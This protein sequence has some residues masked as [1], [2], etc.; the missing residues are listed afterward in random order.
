MSFALTKFQAYGLY[1]DEAVTKKAIQRVEMTITG[2]AADVDLDI[3]DDSGTFW[4]AALADGTYG[5]YATSALAAIQAVVARS[6]ELSRV[7]I[8]SLLD[9]GA[10]VGRTVTK[11]TSSAGAGGGATEAMTVTGLLSTDLVLAVTQKTD[12]ANN[13]PLLGWSTQADDAITGIWSADPGAGAVIEVAFARE[14][15]APSDGEFS[16]AIQNKRPN[17]T[18]AAG[19]GETS[20]KVIMEYLLDEGVQPVKSDIG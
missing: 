6:Q 17:I 7:D 11:I 3:G 16:L 15:G 10:P 14:G 1:I 18:F 2:L 12:G 5:T 19:D 8:G 4:T 13:L 9:R 20:L